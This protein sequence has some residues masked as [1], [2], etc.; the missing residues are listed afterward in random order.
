MD[1]VGRRPVMIKVA[2]TTSVAYLVKAIS[3]NVTCEGMVAELIAMGPHAINQSV[4]AIASARAAVLPNGFD[5]VCV[6]SFYV[7]DEDNKAMKLRVQSIL[8]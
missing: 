8:V 7:I 3:C 5:L 2:S 4:K 1:T 6:P